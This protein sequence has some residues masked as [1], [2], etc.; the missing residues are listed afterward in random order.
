VAWVRDGSPLAGIVAVPR[1]FF[2][3]NSNNYF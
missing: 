2:C 3:E 1:S